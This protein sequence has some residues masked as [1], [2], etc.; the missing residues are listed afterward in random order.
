MSVRLGTK[1][2]GRREELCTNDAYLHNVIVGAQGISQ[3]YGRSVFD[4]GGGPLDFDGNEETFI[5]GNEIAMFLDSNPQMAQSFRTIW[6]GVKMSGLS[7]TAH[8]RAKLG[9]SSNGIN[10][11]Y[12]QSGT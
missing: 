2:R 9:Y 1:G 6:P 8:V 5:D 12:F 3:K 7:P 10:S 11:E 4:C